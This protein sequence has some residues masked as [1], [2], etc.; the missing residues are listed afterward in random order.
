MMIERVGTGPALVLVHG[1]AMHSGIFAPLVDQLR[2]QFEM[3]LV[4]LP[5]HG[6]SR[7]SATALDPSAC[8]EYFSTHLPPAIYL[9]WSLGGLFTLELARAAPQS[10]RGL[11][12]VAATPKFVVADD[13]PEGMP[14][15]IF[16]NFASDLEQNWQSALDRFLMLEAQGS[17]NLR[18]ELRFLRSHI[19]ERGQPNAQA[20]NSGLDLLRFADARDALKHVQAPSLW[21]AG[22]RDRLVSPAAMQRAAS[23]SDAGQFVPVEGAGHAPFLTH[24]KIVAEQITAFHQSISHEASI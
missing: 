15:A 17:E 8:A 10:C 21:L 3:Y 13:W 18:E 14:A 20:L 1:W 4:D 7:N 11:V 24:A 9:G 6:Q 12:M 2:D 16:E 22:R 19:F 5:G 23:Q